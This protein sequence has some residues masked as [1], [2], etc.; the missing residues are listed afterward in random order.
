[1]YDEGRARRPRGRH[2][3]APEVPDRR[4]AHAVLAG[5]YRHRAGGRGGRFAGF[6]PFPTAPPPTADRTQPPHGR[7]RPDS[8]ESRPDLYGG[9]RLL[10]KGGNQPPP[11]GATRAPGPPAPPPP[12]RD[13]PRFGPGGGGCPQGN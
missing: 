5:H 2:R 1:V 11:R 9:G 13:P 6:W 4:R 10:G 3:A 8:G 12:P 7:D